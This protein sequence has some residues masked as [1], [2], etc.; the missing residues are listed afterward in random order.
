MCFFLLCR[1]ARAFQELLYVDPVYCRANEVHLRLG[2]IFKVTGDLES[3]LKQFQLTLIDAAPCSLSP[4]E[5]KTNGKTSSSHPV[6][7]FFLPRKIKKTV[8]K[9]SCVFNQVFLLFLHFPHDT[10]KFHIA[11]LY[12]VCN[13]IKTAKEHY[14]QLLLEK[15]LP[16]LLK[17]D[18]Y[19][20]LGKNN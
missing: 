3:S 12:E 18:I 20:Q 1:A 15:D 16:L 6:P 4:H 19:R 2:L 10:V 9:S 17:A 8:E 13:R 7:F 5:G 11:H 14:E